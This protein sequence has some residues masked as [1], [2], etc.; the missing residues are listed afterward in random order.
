MR[1]ARG[2]IRGMARQTIGI[3][4]VRSAARCKLDRLAYIDGGDEGSAADR[5]RERFGFDEQ[6]R[7]RRNLAGHRRAQRFSGPRWS[8]RGG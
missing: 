4:A 7:Y 6:R 5:Y 1:E 2:L 8:H 3:A